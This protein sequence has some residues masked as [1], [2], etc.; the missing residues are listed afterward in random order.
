MSDHDKREAYQQKLDARLDEWKAEIEKLRAKAEG[1]EADAKV[2]YHEMIEDLTERRQKLM[3]QA[4]EMR[5]ASEERFHKMRETAE[6][7]W[8]DM[9]AATEAAWRKWFS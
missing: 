1:V 5:E 9:S 3:K 4:D 8:K 7:Y 6:Q 2:R